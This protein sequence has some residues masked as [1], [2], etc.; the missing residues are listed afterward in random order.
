MS[1]A[2]YLF[3]FTSLVNNQQHLSFFTVHA[4]LEITLLNTGVSSSLTSSK[5]RKSDFQGC[6]LMSGDSLSRILEHQLRKTRL[7]ITV[8]F[9]NRGVERPERLKKH[10]P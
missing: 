4:T 10:K 7:I 1:F 2:P 5:D 9:V 3:V 8:A 6:F